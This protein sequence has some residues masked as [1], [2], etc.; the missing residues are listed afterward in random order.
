[1]KSEDRLKQYMQQKYDNRNIT[2]LLN[3]IETVIRE[4]NDLKERLAVVEQIMHMH[5]PIIEDK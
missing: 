5:L 3:M 1:M 2:T 4:N